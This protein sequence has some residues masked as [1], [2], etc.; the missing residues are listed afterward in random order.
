MHLSSIHNNNIYMKIV[1]L[2]GYMPHIKNGSVTLNERS[3]L[4]EY[5][6]L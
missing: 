4:H 3:I 6:E 1:I 2:W 5:Y